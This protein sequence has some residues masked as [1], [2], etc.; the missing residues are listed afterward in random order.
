M[1]RCLNEQRERHTHT[2]RETE[3]E[4]E[5]E[6]ERENMIMNSLFMHRLQP[7]IKWLLGK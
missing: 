4:G 1:H 6:R 5:R 2:Y 3:R 7:L